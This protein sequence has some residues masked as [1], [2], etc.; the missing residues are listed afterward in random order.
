M[1]LREF[2]HVF[3]ACLVARGTEE[4]LAEKQVL[5]DSKLLDSSRVSLSNLGFL[6]AIPTVA[7]SKQQTGANQPQTSNPVDDPLLIETSPQSTQ[8][9]SQTDADLIEPDDNVFTQNE[10]MDFFMKQDKHTGKISNDNDP[11]EDVLKQNEVIDNAGTQ[12]DFLNDVLT[13]KV[14]MEGHADS[15]LKICEAEGVDTGAYKIDCRQ[16]GLAEEKSDTEQ[17]ELLKARHSKRALI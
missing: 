7:F 12:N 11:M 16:V 14:L 2:K 15:S 17:H 1:T 6:H 4:D 3:P 5:L 13:Q 9:P 8:H 10:P